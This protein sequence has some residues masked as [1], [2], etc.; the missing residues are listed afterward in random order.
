[1]AKQPGDPAITAAVGERLRRRRE[2]DGLSQERLGEIAGVDRGYVSLVE[3]G[4]V[5]PTVTT[6]VRLA[7]AM[8]MN[9]GELL[10]GLAP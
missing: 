8:G 4:K 9:P 1:M 2:Q 10:E 7:A 6:L 3:R 5:N